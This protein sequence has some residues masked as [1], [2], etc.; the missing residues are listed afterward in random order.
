M[1]SMNAKDDKTMQEHEKP[2]EDKIKYGHPSKS[3][4]N[5]FMKAH[6]QNHVSQ[7]V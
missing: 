5:P 7:T 6:P 3:L 1:R 4:P 2:W